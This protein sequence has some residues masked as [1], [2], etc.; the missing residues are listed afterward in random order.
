MSATEFGHGTPGT[1][2]RRVHFGE[3][4]H[5]AQ[6]AAVRW[7]LAGAL[8]QASTAP[9]APCRWCET[10]VP[11]TQVVVWAGQLQPFTRKKGLIG[12]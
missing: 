10:S 11:V 3:R 2:D 12:G 5:G 8:A 9:S 6:V 1:S 7:H 4:H